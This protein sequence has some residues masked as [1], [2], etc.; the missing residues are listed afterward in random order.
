MIIVGE[1][2]ISNRM[3]FA[4]P[5]QSDIRELNLNKHPLTIKMSVLHGITAG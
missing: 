4:S 2:I 3:L 5:S 1:G